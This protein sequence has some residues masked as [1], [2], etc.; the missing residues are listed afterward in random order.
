MVSNEITYK[1]RVE[2]KRIIVHDSHTPPEIHQIHE[3]SRWHVDAHDGALRM[4]LLSIGYHFII[5]RDGTVVLCRPV[6][7]IGTHAPGNNMD[8]IGICLVGGRDHDGN[9]EENFTREQRKNLLKLIGDL[10]KRYGH[11]DV[12]GKTEVQRYRNRA[13]PPSPFLDMDLLREDIFLYE[14]GI[15]I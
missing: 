4:G 2:T 12:L 6:E 1:D 5:E 14:Q 9:A 3:V 10:K 7:K 11:L 15:M 8:S 13:L